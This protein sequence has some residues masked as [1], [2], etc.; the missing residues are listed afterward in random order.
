M[1]QTPAY[2]VVVVGGGMVG[3]S[4]AVALAREGFSVAVVEASI[5]EEP[6]ADSAPA[7]RV[8]AINAAS[9]RFFQ[10]LGVWRG[11]LSRR[12]M[13]YAAMQVWDEG[14]SGSVRFDA[15]ELHAPALGHIVENWV[16]QHALLDALGSEAGIELLAPR[17]PVRFEAA[18]DVAR[19]EL[20][21]GNIVTAR[22]VV[23]ADGARSGMRELAG[24]EVDSR[25]YGQR[26]LVTTVRTEQAHEA[27]AW[28]RFLADGPLAFLPLW[29]GSSSIVWSTLPE[30]AEWLVSLDEA[31]FRAR[32]G[33][34]FDHRLG[35]ILECGPRASFP[36]MRQ[37]AERYVGPRLALV[38]D[39]AH[40]VHP[41]AGQGANL[42]FMDAAALVEVL[43]RT[44]D[45]GRDIGGETRLKAYQRW[46]RGQNQLMATVMDGFDR[47]FRDQA[48]PLRLARG[49]GF[50]LTQRVAPLKSLMA[51]HAM[52]DSF[53]LPRIARLW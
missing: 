27:T 37:D 42:G 23:A 24:I 14:S 5:A 11:M 26:A 17:K 49:I 22:L 20:D 50:D 6:A 35:G 12:V 31:D 40:V 44:R 43:V 25:P 8:S 48:I 18:A 9:T 15:A 36:L 51:R 1:K 34:A 39:A 45:L 52:G 29:D 53:D 32:L 33:A 13:P 7:M 41:L 3:A 19:L 46:R 2:D 28:Q 16:V 30:Q 21:D 38:G 47:L 10:H 4:L